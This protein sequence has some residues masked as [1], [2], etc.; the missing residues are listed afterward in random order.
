M[1]AQANTRVRGSEK[2]EPP[3][4]HLCGV[5]S[6][7]ECIVHQMPRP[8]TGTAVFRAR[9]PV[10]SGH[11]GLRASF[12]ARREGNSGFSGAR[13]GRIGERSR[14]AAPSS[15]RASSPTLV[16]RACL[17]RRGSL[18]LLINLESR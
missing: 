17:G 5:L 10:P 16:G 4:G 8:R 1:I 13:G 12:F 15:N 3:N 18:T 14:K 9:R 11:F 7:F 2:A 6:R